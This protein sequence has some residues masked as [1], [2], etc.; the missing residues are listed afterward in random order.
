M[1]ILHKITNALANRLSLGSRAERDLIETVL[2]QLPRATYFR[3]REQEFMPGGIVDVGAH[4]GQWTRMIREVFPTSP[5][6]MVE[7]RQEQELILQQLCA[8]TSNVN[9]V[10]ALLGREP[11]ATVPFQVSDTGSSIFAERSDAPRT[12][13]FLPMRT[14]DDVA[15][16]IE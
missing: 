13:R 16:G 11:V 9:Y 7:A 12:P 14:L 5:V 2:R 8:E 1:S 3:L 10:I 15:L 6:L 4:D